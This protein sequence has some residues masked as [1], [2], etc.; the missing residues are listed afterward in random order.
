MAIVPPAGAVASEK[1]ISSMGVTGLRF[2]KGWMNGAK[3][4]PHMRERTGF[5]PP[6]AI[7]ADKGMTARHE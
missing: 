5:S 4:C 1:A 7:R 3:P 6:G 2:D